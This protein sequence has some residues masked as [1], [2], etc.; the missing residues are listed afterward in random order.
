MQ[1]SGEY[2]DFS[3]LTRLRPDEVVR[4]SRRVVD[5]YTRMTAAGSRGQ[6]GSFGAFG[7]WRAP[8]VVE[9]RTGEPLIVLIDF[10]RWSGTTANRKF[11]EG[12]RQYSSWRSR[13]A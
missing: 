5:S 12:L 1:V 9:L 2:L 8:V 13:V 7:K 6:F 11:I 4:I 10:T 3:G